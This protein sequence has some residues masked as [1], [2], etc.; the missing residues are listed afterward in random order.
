[1]RDADPESEI[2]IIEACAVVYQR[3][4]AERSL[5]PED[6]KRL[7]AVLCVISTGA[8]GPEIAAALPAGKGLP[9][10][11]GLVSMYREARQSGSRP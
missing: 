2:Q 6:K 1:M 8:R 11:E 10:V 4:T 3:L 5:S 9:G 7:Y